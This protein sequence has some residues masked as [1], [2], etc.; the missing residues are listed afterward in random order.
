MTRIATVGSGFVGRSW[1]IVFARGGCTV[2]MHDPIP[3]ALDAAR[4]AI[5]A[6]LAEMAANGLIDEPVATVAARIRIEPDLAAA[7]ADVD[8]VQESSPER[9]P[10]KRALF[11]DLDRMTR[12]DAILAT[13]T[14][15]IPV[16]AIA[17]DLPG[18]ARCIVAHPANPPHLLPAIEMVP[19]D[20]TST[21]TV[22]T[23]SR[24]LRWVGQVPV[25]MRE[26]DGFVM[27]R[28]QAALMAE[29]LSLVGAGIADATAI[30][31]VVRGSLGPRWAFM[32]P[33]ETMDLNAPGGFPDYAQRYGPTMAKLS[34]MDERWPEETVAAADVALR[35][36]VPA[37]AL[38]Q[39][40]AWRDRRLTALAAH[41]RGQEKAEG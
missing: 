12:P 25:P 26:I 2:A 24:I 10:L 34:G 30:D 20:F 3:A 37:E 35:A 41:L 18:R 1:A 23:A 4:D 8:Y 14:S 16:S 40:R 19:A 27:N 31:A 17:H 11:A 15:G 39:R 9:L 6:A 13:S 38:G 33:F 5:D 22:E 36:A 29:A 28:L 21:E 32:G 7:V